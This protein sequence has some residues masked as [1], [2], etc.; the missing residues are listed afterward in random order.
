MPTIGS[1]KINPGTG[2]ISVTPSATF[3]AGGNIAPV[4]SS[5]GVQTPNSGIQLYSALNQTAGNVTL[6]LNNIQSGAGILLSLSGGVITISSNITVGPTGPAG[7]SVTGPTGPAGVTGP[8][9][10]TGATGATGPTGPGGM[11]VTGPTGPAG[12]TGATGVTGSTGPTGPGGATDPTNLQ[13]GD[14]TNTLILV[15][16]GSY[17]PITPTSVTVQAETGGTPI[18]LSFQPS[19]STT[20]FNGFVG[21]GEAYPTLTPLANIDL[22]G[23]MAANVTSVASTSINCSTANWFTKTISTS[24]TFTFDNTPASRAFEFNLEIINGGSASVTWPTSVKWGNGVPPVL[25]TSGTDI[26][27][28]VTFNGGSAW[29]GAVFVRNGA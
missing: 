1:G 21:I 13:F 5:F 20:N 8:T 24:T 11:S 23:N 17:T 7:E 25:T 16:S 2:S 3:P 28:F 4:L 22:S 27:S 15:A 19:G 14:G 10:S 18:P 9:G 6:T 29:Y 26:L 12:S